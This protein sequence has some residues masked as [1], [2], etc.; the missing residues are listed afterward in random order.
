[1]IDLHELAAQAHLGGPIPTLE[2]VAIPL[3]SKVTDGPADI[4]PGLLPRQG[5]V[6]LA[7]ETNVGKSL[8][9]LEIISSLVTGQPLWGQI[10]PTMVAKKVVYI[11]GEHHNEVIQRLW[12]KTK[13]PMTDNVW[14]LGPE[15]LSFDK[16]LV[17]QGRPNVLAIE[18][19]KKW[20]DGADLVVFDPLS[21]FTVGMDAENDNIGMR[22][23]LEMMNLITTQ[24]GAVYI[25][26]AHQ[27]KPLMDMK[28][29]EHSR[30]SYAI[31]G[32]SAIEDAATNI[33]YMGQGKTQTDAKK[34]AGIKVFELTCR[35]YKGEAKERY[36]LIRD[37]GTLTHTLGG[38]AP[39][40]EV[41]SFEMRARVH[42]IQ[43]ENPSMTYRAAKQMLA[44]VE[45]VS[46]DTVERW[47][48][49]KK[50]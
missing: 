44:T 34:Q 5:G 49:N 8:L 42:R 35:K 43:G 28:G 23:L 20:T 50:V 27:G 25:A 24:A 10:E 31:R 36:N 45:G 38:D 2:Q 41:M 22:L 39:F 9:S 1:M 32:A 48:E 47:L 6:V 16:W 33:F 46:L 26:L 19:F 13:L 40:A 12:Q 15:Q 30:K 7:G 14:L 18:K 4:F 29:E 37:A 21:S 17:T 3:I 11:L